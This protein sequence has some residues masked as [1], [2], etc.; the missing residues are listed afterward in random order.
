MKLKFTDYSGQARIF[1]K[2]ATANKYAKACKGTV[3][4]VFGQFVVY[5]D[6]GWIK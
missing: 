3:Y 4:K 1:A 6:N 2:K 5:C